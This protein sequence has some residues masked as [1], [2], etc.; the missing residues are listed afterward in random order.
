VAELDEFTLHAAMSPGRIVR[1]DADHE[2]PDCGCRRRPTGTAPAGVVPR[3]GDQHSTATITAQGDVQIGQKIDQH[4]TATIKSVNGSIDI[5]QGLS[6]FVTATLIAPNGDINIGDSVNSG[7]TLNWNALQLN[8][9]HQDGI[10]N[11]I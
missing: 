10:I 11:H 1:R 8:C 4:S 7:S 3:A 6:G 5:G 2:L 9:P